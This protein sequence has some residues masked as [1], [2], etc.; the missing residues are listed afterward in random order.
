MK[1][2]L[3]LHFAVTVFLTGGCIKETYDMDRLSGEMHLSPTFVCSAATGE[4]TLG[5]LLV[6]NDTI[7]YDG[8]KLCR[9][10]YRKDSVIDLRLKD[11]YD[12]DNM[13]DYDEVYTLGEVKINDF[14]TSL[15]ISLTQM[16]MLFSAT[17][18]NQL[19]SL[20]DGALHPFPSLP[21]VT[22]PE[23]VFSPQLTNMEYATFASGAI[24]ITV[25]NEL[26]TSLYGLRV[27][28]MNSSDHTVIGN[29]VVFSSIPAGA[30][31]TGSVNLANQYVT[32][33]IT[34]IVTI[35]GSP[36]NTD[37][38]L[39]DMEHSLKFSVKSKDLKVLNGRIILPPQLIEEGIKKDTIT[40]DPGD[41][42]EIEKLGISTGNLNYSLQ[43]ASYVK[44]SFTVT[45]PSALQDGN[46]V[47]K[48]IILNPGSTSGGSVNLDNTVFDLSWDVNQKYNRVPVEYAINISSGSEMIN[49]SSGDNI[50]AVLTLPDPELDYVKGYFGQRIETIR[51]TSVDI[52]MDRFFS[53]ISGDFRISSPMVTVNYSNSFGVPVEIQLNALGINDGGTVALSRDAFILSCP[54]VTAPR[55]TSSTVIIDK[56][57]SKLVEMI[58]MLPDEIRFSGTARM[59]P[60][61]DNGASDNYLFGNSRIIA[62]IY[63]D[64]PMELRISDLQF[65]ETV[66]NFLDSG[67]KEGG[68]SMRPEDF[69]FLKINLAVSNG[70]PLGASVEMSLYDSVRKI[71][72]STVEADEIIKP[73]PVDAI[74][75]VTGPAESSAGIEFTEDFFKSVGNA[76]KVVF[77]FIMQ[78]TDDGTRDVK[79]YSD[80][81]LTF[82][83][84]LMVTPEIKL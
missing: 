32:K 11:Y 36:G 74:G 13:V 48:T 18:R 75:R 67:D 59:N 56:S 51:S 19:I 81:K 33:A 65:T 49:F 37:P 42:M 69:H 9:I 40:I 23:K 7:V 6:A 21:S 84:T 27:K 46:Q 20:D 79:I 22:L 64:I 63:V 29:E 12:F 26:N 38:V 71:N 8:D 55:D 53:R 73:A 78:S 35:N 61:G 70:F 77:K 68:H 16:S 52:G 47:S 30:T 41:G 1:K 4:I 24:D 44:T 2:Y 83:A 43:T 28:L 31:V 58:S 34:T 54:G 45:L 80:Y 25:K 62:G 10:I 82:R 3:L 76:D 15:G 66:D 60:G 50:R 39:I 5:D 57:N 17:L 72:I 14:Q